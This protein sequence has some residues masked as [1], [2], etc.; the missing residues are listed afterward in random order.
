MLF[1]SLAIVYGP[2]DPGPTQVSRWG[3]VLAAA[4]LAYVLIWNM[5]TIRVFPREYVTFPQWFD[6]LGYSIR[7]DQRWAMFAPYPL[8]ED[9]WYVIVGELADKSTVDVFHGTRQIYWG[10][11]E[12]GWQFYRDFRWQKFLT[13]MA[14][15]KNASMRPQYADYVC[16]QWNAQHAG[17]SRLKSITIYYV[18]IGR[19]HV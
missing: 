13:N 15:V 8:R 14:N 5:R 11:P 19:A 6:K 7:L 10:K 18:K 17:K 2:T 12:H 1:R 16:R 3:S 9:G 4:A